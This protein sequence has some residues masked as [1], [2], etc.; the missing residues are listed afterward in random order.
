MSLILPETVKANLELER[1]LEAVSR[2][3]AH[4]DFLLWFDR[5][6]KNL[7][8]RLSLVK[9][10]ERAEPPLV[11][12]YWH[13]KRENEQAVDSYMPIAG[14][15]GEFVEPHSGVL[16]DLE[17]SDLQRP[18]VL[19]ALTERQQRSVRDRSDLKQEFAERIEQASKTSV[20]MSSKRE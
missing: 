12:G 17:A 18:G 13:V 6:L 1:C 5:E 11:A 15:D 10:S 2:A 19:E 4:G 3:H 14:A 7:D 20:S 16:R 8:S 9:A